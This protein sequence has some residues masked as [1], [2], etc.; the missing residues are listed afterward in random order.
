MTTR[1]PCPEPGQL[2]LL[3]LGRLTGAAAELL[4]THLATCDHCIET[5]QSVPGEDELVRSLREDIVC[6][7]RDL[8]A[9]MEISRRRRR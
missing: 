4:E 2:E 1:R 7:S 6:E 3:I 5:L 9:S 8:A